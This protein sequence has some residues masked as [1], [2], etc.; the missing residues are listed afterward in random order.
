[1]IAR[2]WKDE[3]GA[4]AIEY[5][6]VAVLMSLAVI[7]GSTVIGVSLASIF[8]YLADVFDAVV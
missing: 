7:A 2:L 8:Q 1:M 4:T 3:S 6:L 5:G